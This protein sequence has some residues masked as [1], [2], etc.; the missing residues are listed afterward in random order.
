MRATRARGV[1]IMC[2][3]ASASFSVAVT[4]AVIGIA[5]LRQVGHPRDLPLA[6]VPL[7]FAFQ[8]TV[9]GALWLQLSGAG[10]SGQVAVLSFTFLIF[11]KILWPI[12]TPLAALLIEPDRRRRRV[13]CVIAVIGFALSIYLLTDLLGD[14]VSVTIRDRSIGYASDV[15]PASWRQLPYLLC[16]CFAL[17]FSSHRIVQ[18]LGVLMLVGFTVSA[19]AYLAAFISVWCFFAA[20]ASSVIYLYFR[21]AA[22]AVRLS[23]H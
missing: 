14:P 9:E 1:D 17:L 12:Y 6:A 8:Q 20:A 4:T 7:L 3:S 2:F 22:M 23:S 10:D 16:T 5:A 15:D 19:Y 13:F 18:V 11:A 21:R